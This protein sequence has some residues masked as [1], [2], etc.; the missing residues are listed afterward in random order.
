MHVHTL[1]RCGWCRRA[2][3]SPLFTGDSEIDQIFRIMQ[4]LG[5]P[6]VDQ[7]PLLPRLPDYSPSFPKFRGK[8]RPLSL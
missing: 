1:A 6:T 4:A 5:T 3:G 2:S 7:W 8:V